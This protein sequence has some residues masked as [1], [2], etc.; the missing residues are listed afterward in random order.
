MERKLTAGSYN[1]YKTILD[2]L[3]A[4]SGRIVEGWAA[5]VSKSQLLKGAEFSLPDEVRVDRMRAFFD[6][7]VGRATDP[8]DQVAI[9]TLKAVI[10][11]EHSRSLGLTSSIKKQSLLRDVMLSVA[12][13]ELP[14]MPR[15]TV[16]LALDAMIDRSIEWTVAMAEDYI[17]MRE[18]LTRCLPGPS[19]SQSSLDQALSR[20]C[21][22]VMDYFEADFVAVFRYDDH[23]KA[24]V[25]Q[26]CSA[27][28]L[29]LS[30]DSTVL[31]DS[32]PLAAQAISSSKTAL[33]EQEGEAKAKKRLFGRLSF[34]HAACLPLASSGGVIGLLVIGDNTRRIPF[35]LEE[36]AL[37]EDLAGQ[38]AN[39]LESS[40]LF[41]ELDIRARGQK[42]L[43]ETAAA[44][45]QEI[46]SSEIYRVVA[47]KLTEIIP[48]D[49]VAFYV[50]DW[51]RRVGNPV[52]ASGPYAAEIMADR[53]FPADTGIA[54]YVARSKKAEIIP[55]TEADPRGAQIPGTP[56]MKT[57]MLAVPVIG[58]REVLGVIELQRYPPR[59][60]TNEDLEIAIMF[61]NHASV[62][63]ENA[64]L[65]NEVRRAR[66][67]IELHIDLLT[68]DI[69]NYTTPIMACFEALRARKDLDPQISQAVERTLRQVE[70][71]MAM[72]EMVRTV[73]RVREEPVRSLRS[74][75]LRRAIEEAV[76]EVKG[77]A[78]R[79]DLEISIEL[80]DGPMMVLADDML[81][82]V[83]TNLFRSATMPDR[84]EKTRLS[85]SAQLR[86]NDRSECWWVR[87]AQPN[88]LIP[89]HMKGEVFRLIKGSK[90][91]LAGGFTIGLAAAKGVVDRYSGS[92]WVSD[93]V[94]GDYSK[95]CVFNIMLPRAG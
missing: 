76:S 56:K 71:V 26:A 61:A 25:C 33:S 40:R 88:R 80:P 38:L 21:K 77:R 58:Q 60:Y 4:N 65:L 6:A 85:L 18:A 68:H 59:R 31:L 42:A 15:H 11:G 37:A 78:Y 30:K 87:I 64:K 29:T 43:I 83:F 12:E 5:S 89:N 51:S 23:G 14:D 19:F 13:H 94:P 69:A 24:L 63:L 48:S 67:Q 95:G 17:E 27:K 45:Q 93:I 74:M 81:K 10:R 28:G 57:T 35:T 46:D 91:Q 70:N 3:K 54:G 66:D 39:A 73:A 50:Y 55:D 84:G 36:I 20:F 52:Y 90:S 72:V 92:I 75:D 32:F 7:L 86:K 62:A 44:L 53:D 9:E 41:Q 2:V 49:E 1:D 8:D 22:A 34:S 79:D 16:K 47:T 82:E